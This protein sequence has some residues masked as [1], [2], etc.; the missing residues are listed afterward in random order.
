MQQSINQ[1][2]KKIRV[3]R[4]LTQSE[5]ADSISI[6]R[7]Q[8]SQI[9]AEKQ[10]PTIETLRKIATIY[11]VNYGYLIDGKPQD[12]TLKEFEKN[13]QLNPN[14]I[15]NLNPNLNVVSDPEKGYVKETRVGNMRVLAITVNEKQEEII[16]FVPSMA[17][18]GYLSGF[19]DPEYVAALPS[20]SITGFCHNTVL[21][22][23]LK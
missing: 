11:G 5:F 12:E 10:L 16:K 23:H 8:Y 18:A 19:N 2:V 20:I 6:S 21:I 7:S 17:Q 14:L 15:P 13:A 22:A 4:N 3:T 9:E 1:R